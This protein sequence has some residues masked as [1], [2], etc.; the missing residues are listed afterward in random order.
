MGMVAGCVFD[1]AE[2][3]ASHKIG[4]SDNDGL[5]TSYHVVAMSLAYGSTGEKKYLES[6]KEGMHA[7]IMLQNASGTQGLVARSV[8]PISEREQ[9]SKQ[10]RETPDGKLLWKSDT[11]SDEIDGHFF[12]F[13]AYWEH[14]AKHYPEESALIKEQIS[15]VMNYIVDNNYQLIDWDGERTRWGFWN[16]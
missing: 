9:K 1:D 16:P 2:N 8:V 11:S 10:W 15:T 14:I 7:M 6:A 13:Y 12:A 5:W 3:P 4:Y